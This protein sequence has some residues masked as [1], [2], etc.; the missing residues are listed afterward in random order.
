MKGPIFT[1]V[2]WGDQSSKKELFKD[3]QLSIFSRAKGCLPMARRI[4]GEGEDTQH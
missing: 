3:S 2:Y 4:V 1:M